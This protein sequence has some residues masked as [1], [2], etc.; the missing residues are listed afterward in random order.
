MT[1]DL[2]TIT[3]I[4]TLL[5]R[6]RRTVAEGWVQRPDFPKPVYAPTRATRLWSRADVERWAAPK[7]KQ[8]AGV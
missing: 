1:H 7:E 5:R 8:H 3:E 4:A 2:L 6:S